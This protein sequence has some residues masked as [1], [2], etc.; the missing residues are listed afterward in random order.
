M[1]QC[2]LLSIC[3]ACL[4]SSCFTE[5]VRAHAQALFRHARQLTDIRSA[6][7]PAF[8]LTA[9][10]FFVGKDLENVQGT[11]SVVGLRVHQV[12][13]HEKTIRLATSKNGEPRVVAL[14][15]ECL[16]LL[17]A[18]C[19]GKRQDAYVFSRDGDGM[20][21]IR[22]FRERWKKLFADAKVPFKQFHDMRRSAA[23]EMI[24]SGIDDKTCMVIGGWKTAAV[25]KRYRI[26]DPHDLR[27]AARK[28]EEQRERARAAF[29]TDTKTDTFEKAAAG[30]ERSLQ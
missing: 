20:A 26:V 14:T 7:S 15:T 22:D 17:T 30:D 10:F 6:G 21:P 28:I 9:T 18:C 8:R 29:S 19:E 5:D 4:Q 23:R 24:H 1:R 12:D 16:M 11:Y 2:I 3:L 27:E 25:F 13:L